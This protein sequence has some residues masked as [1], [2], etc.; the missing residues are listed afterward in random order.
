MGGERGIGSQQ[1][2]VGKTPENV[3]IGVDDDK[4]RNAAVERVA[5]VDASHQKAGHGS[6]AVA[7]ISRPVGDA[8]DLAQVQAGLVE[9]EIEDEQVVVRQQE[10]VE[11]VGIGHIAGVIGR[12][13]AGAVPAESN[14]AT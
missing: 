11:R 12:A 10:I 2:L 5:A 8:I 4:L 7:E 9:A 3:V 1:E 13:S 14:S 6:Q